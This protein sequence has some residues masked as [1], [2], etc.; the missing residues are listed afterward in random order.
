MCGTELLYLPASHAATGTLLV[1]Y[2]Q[3]K[4]G[5]APEKLKGSL[6]F[7]PISKMMQKGKDVSAVIATGKELV[8]TLAA[9]PH[10]RLH[11]RELCTVEQRRSLHLSGIRIRTGMGK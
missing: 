3:K 4:K 6:N 5:Y 10:F 11:C 7:D 8:E 1:A 9:Y 2:F